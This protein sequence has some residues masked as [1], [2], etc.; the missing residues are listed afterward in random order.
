ME[1]QE[2]AGLL[3]LTGVRL[4]DLWS[5]DEST[6]LDR[7]LARAVGSAGGRPQEA[8]SAFNSAV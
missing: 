5:L 3:D 8:A 6:V 4:R 7:S 2:G 1:E